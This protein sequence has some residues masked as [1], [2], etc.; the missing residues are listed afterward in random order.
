MEIVRRQFREGMSMET[1]ADKS[2][3]ARP[4]CRKTWE[5]RWPVAERGVSFIGTRS[6]RYRSLY[7]DVTGM[8]HPQLHRIAQHHPHSGCGAAS[9]W[10]QKQLAMQPH[11]HAHD[12]APATQR[13]SVTKLTLIR[14]NTDV[15]VTS[16]LHLV[17]Q[18]GKL[19]QHGWHRMA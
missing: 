12:D 9:I 13:Q 2:L 7:R 15:T 5:Q 11:G 4:L 10:L 14:D 18:N 17:A 3:C 19:V 1:C 8:S 6:H 16:I